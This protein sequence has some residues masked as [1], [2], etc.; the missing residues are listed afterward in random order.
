MSDIKAD[1]AGLYLRSCNMAE[2]P[3]DRKIGAFHCYYCWDSICNAQDSV[4]Q[5]SVEVPSS[6][7]CRV[8]LHLSLCLLCPRRRMRFASAVVLIS[9]SHQNIAGFDNVRNLI[10]FDDE[11]QQTA[12]A[13]NSDL[14]H[15]IDVTNSLANLCS[16]P[17]E[18]LS[19]TR[20]M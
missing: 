8:R 16:P 18:S 11:P 19:R 2:T 3:R 9:G 13:Q 4:G 5:S 17:L 10:R 7:F 14:C 1:Q 20:S 15:C 12:Y 6:V